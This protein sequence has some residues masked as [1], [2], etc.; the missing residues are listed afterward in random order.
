[1][2]YSTISSAYCQDFPDMTLTKLACICKGLRGLTHTSK[3]PSIVQNF[4]VKDGRIE[5]IRF[6]NGMEHRFYTKTKM[7]EKPR[8]PCCKGFRS[9]FLK[10]KICYSI[11]IASP[12]EKNLYRSAI[13][14]R[15]AASVFP[16]PANADTS[17]IRVLSG[18]WKFVISP[19][20][21]LNS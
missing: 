11:N 7:T 15:Y 18:K 19:S 20:M 3:L 14:S 6:K 1:M 13:A 2:I 12:N 5:S 4:C 10:I 17:I 8:I 21:H 9:Y 16:R